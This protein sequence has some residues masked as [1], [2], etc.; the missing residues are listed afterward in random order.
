M[1]DIAR[2][3]EG[4]RRQ[5]SVHAAGVVIGDE[6]L[7]N[8]TPL[9]RTQDGAG[10]IVTQYE[11]HAVGN[12]G[13]LK[14]DF[15]GLR[16]LTVIEDA[17]RYIE[18]TRGTKIDI[19]NVPLDDRAT[20]GML[21]RG[22]TIAV[23]QL[24]SPGMRDLVKKL[25]PDRFEDVMAL[26]ALYR[27]GP[28]GE[29]MHFEYAMRKH[30]Q[31]T[32]EYLHPDLKP[33][34]QET[35]GI[36]LYQEQALRIAVDMAGFSMGDA[37]TL[38]KAIG[39]KSG[40]VMRAQREKFVTGC[41]TKGYTKDLGS[42]MFEMIEHFAGYGF[43]KSHSCG[44]AYIAYQT[45]YLKAHYPVEYIAALLTSVRDKQDRTALYLAECRVMGITV[46]PPDVNRSESDY[47]PLP[48][49]E[50][51]S[52]EIRIGLSAIRNVG[53]NVVSEIIRE[54]ETKGPFASFADFCHRVDPTALNK[55]VVESFV[56][57]GAFDSLGLNRPEL[58][59]WGTD[60]RTGDQRLVLSEAAGKMLD[61]AAEDRRNE[62]AGQSSL[63]GV[64][65]RHAMTTV[66]SPMASGADISR[67]A[68][69]AAEK[70]MLGLYVS[71]HPL[72]E[73]QQAMRASTDTQIADVASAPEGSTRTVG[74]IV[75]RFAKKFTKKGEAMAV[76]V[77]EDLAGAIEIVV[78]P[79]SFDKFAP[80]L[81]RDAIVCVKGK[82][83]LRDED[84]KLVALE[85]WRPN[86]E[87]GGDP[88]VLSLEAESCTPKVVERL[89]EV[90]SSHPGLTPVHLRLTSGTGTKVLRL[91]DDFRIERRNGL[92]AELKSLLGA[93]SL[94]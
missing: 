44:Y 43:N 51:K 90:L 50:G 80:L 74:G 60:T 15:L 23:F 3:L 17:V 58:L 66:S 10:G 12:L 38:R 84:P 53:E 93:T 27:P 34:L 20:Y 25:Q 24:E 48:P 91:P 54:R 55:R 42:K 37:D 22:D 73:V 6:P 78:F 83:D 21:S 40:S 2:E 14:M 68:L 30:G 79:N 33:I 31:R 57:A 11:M 18:R 89:K 45:A 86:L 71:D 19:D 46:D 28:I 76:I 16:N 1:L 82:V 29:R 70:E 41:V 75:G 8:Y 62:Q 49:E 81:Q 56:K 13:L 9:Q 32:V 63:F 36:I 85:V 72:L 94:R 5:V 77:L 65:E 35:F 61:A 92:Y 52:G 7:V 59:T 87:A 26:V 64:D 4:L 47:T 88:L 69:L 67:S 39:K